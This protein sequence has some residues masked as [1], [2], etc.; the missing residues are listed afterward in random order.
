MLQNLSGKKLYLDT[1][2][3]IYFINNNKEFAS[4]SRSLFQLIDNQQVTA[5]AGELCLAELLVKPTKDKKT[6]EIKY[7]HELFDKQFIH[8][9]PHQKQVFLLA[10]EIRVNDGLKMVDAIH[11]ATAI[12]YQ[13]DVFVTGDIK[14]A[15]SVTDIEVLDLNEFV[16]LAP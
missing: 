16:N 11:V 5:Y 9:L 14:I 10:V 3:I 7:I 13:C 8:L 12:Y 2:P 6:Q 15:K 1:N 4:V